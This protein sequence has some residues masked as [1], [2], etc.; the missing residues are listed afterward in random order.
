[1]VEYTSFSKPIKGSFGRAL[2][3]S[4]STMT[5]YSSYPYDLASLITA[6]DYG[7]RTLV[8]PPAIFEK[9][10]GNVPTLSWGVKNDGTPPCDAD[11]YYQS[12]SII[13]LLTVAPTEA[14]TKTLT[15]QAYRLAVKD[16]SAAVPGYGELGG[17]LNTNQDFSFIQN[18]LYT[19]ASTKSIAATV[20]VGKIFKGVVT[21][22]G[23]V[24]SCK[25]GMGTNVHG[26][27]SQIITADG[28]YSFN[29]LITDP[30]TPANAC[31]ITWS[32]TPNSATVNYSLK[33]YGVATVT[34]STPL[35]F[36][37]TA[38]DV[39]ITPTGVTDWCLTASGGYAFA[40]I[41][42]NTAV[43]ATNGATTNLG[44][45]QPIQG[46]DEGIRIWSIL[47]GQTT[48][49]E[50]N[51]QSLFPTWTGAVPDG[52]TVSGVDANN[53]F[54]RV[55]GGC[56]IVSN[57]TAGVVIT[58]TIS[59]T[60]GKRYRFLVRKSSWVSGS[61]RYSAGGAFTAISTTNLSNSSGNGVFAI[62]VTAGATG[63]GTLQIARD[64]TGSTDYVIS[65]FSGKELAPA[66]GTIVH[67]GKR[68]AGSAELP[69]GTSHNDIT[70]NGAIPNLV[71][72]D[73]DRIV[74]SYDGA[75]NPVKVTE[76][77][78]NSYIASIVEFS[79]TLLK[80][81]VGYVLCNQ[82]GVAQSAIT[83]SHATLAGGATFDGSYN[84]LTDLIFGLSCAVP[85]NMKQMQISESVGLGDTE[86]IRRIARY[87]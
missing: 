22:T 55:A 13:N 83:W 64:N 10:A 74:K 40:P 85:K 41:P 86:I 75:N 47:N 38:G 56:R 39:T 78:K 18:A 68:L 43:V 59:V 71:Y 25:F 14:V 2:R 49:N 79:G 37:A 33:E 9:S 36:T 8:G 52:Y 72:M 24:G 54:E 15:A 4:T 30:L 46:T 84:A 11:G 51:E 27:F 32:L 81:R 62:E 82:A 45:R 76:W 69:V 87:V 17:E 28:T 57:N 34:P 35:Q 3:G 16:G 63:S 31:I 20:A 19:V 26:S 61:I 73:E 67:F 48:G 70:A 44:L 77:V 66:T 42:Y 53:Y 60:S 23:L 21:I 29:L 5:R 12:P 1:V 7:I 6:G 50:L 80:F 65:E 58:K